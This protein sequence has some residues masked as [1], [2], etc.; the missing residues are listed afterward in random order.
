MLEETDVLLLDEPTNHLDMKSV[1]W[2][3]EYLQKFK[4]TVLTISHDRY[5]LDQRRSTG[6]WSFVGG[7]AAELPAAIIPSTSRKSRPASNSQLKQYEQEQAQAAAAGLH[8][9]NG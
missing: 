1:E 8:A 4:G 3:E 2:L 6:S 5:F 9:W 7:K